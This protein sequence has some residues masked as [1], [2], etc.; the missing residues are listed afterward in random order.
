MPAA[1]GSGADWVQLVPSHS[2]A[3]PS[4][5]G[6][7]WPPL[8]TIRWRTGSYAIACC[9]R[10]GGDAEGA[11]CDQV[12]PFQPQV[13]ARDTPLLPPPNRITCCRAAS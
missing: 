13:S 1:T 5:V 12:V 9:E 4:T 10:A 7:E 2:Q 3:S 8:I 6:P 11:N